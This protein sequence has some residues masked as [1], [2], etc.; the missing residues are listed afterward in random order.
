MLH[1]AHLHHARAATLLRTKR[2]DDYR[3]E[4]VANHPGVNQDLA[5]L[6]IAGFDNFLYYEWPM[7][8]LVVQASRMTLVHAPVLAARLHAEV[9]E[10]AGPQ[11]PAR[12][13]RVPSTTP[14]WPKRECVSGPSAR[15][16]TRPSSLAS[17][18]A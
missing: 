1:D 13:R 6:A 4:F 15:S 7:T 5:E 2:A 3:A 11:R 18:V 8:R 16:I 10:G 14:N 12:P 17:S 9:P